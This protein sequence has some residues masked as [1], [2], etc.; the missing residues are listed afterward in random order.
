VKITYI[1]N[2]GPDWSTESHIAA[3][4]EDMG[5]EVV[6]A[7]ERT[8]GI[9]LA[10]ELHK[11]HGL[12][13][14][15]T[16]S[17][18]EAEAKRSDLLLWTRTWGIDD[19]AGLLQRLAAEGVPTVAYHLDL[20]AGLERSKTLRSEPWWK[21]KHV[22]TPDGGS[23]DFWK[24]HGVNHHYLRPG[25]FHRE[26]YL[27]EPDPK[28]KTDVAFVGSYGYH[29]E[30]PY[31]RQLVD[32]LRETYRDRFRLFGSGGDTVRGEALNRLYAS[33][34]VCVGDSLCKDFVHER[35][36]SDRVHETPGR[37]GV[38]VMPRI[39]GLDECYVD[40]EEMAFYEFGNFEALKSWI[41]ELLENT[42]LRE[43]MRLAGH[44]RT[45]REHT[46]EHRLAEMFTVLA[47]HE[48]A[49]AKRLAA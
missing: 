16:T 11:N 21:C 2:F 45:K 37:G 15:W 7:Q 25:V 3:T 33:T 1:G 17:A 5:H 47:Q 14:G 10:A 44:V 46:Y 32:W 41:D 6:R 20:Y 39:V 29:P 28:Y 30:W 34:K 27:G 49:I 19:G 22:F 38:L 43:K 24:T 8:T 13:V 4:L 18:I 12:G 35:Y 9:A 40:G 42:E 48:P 36:W 31:R 23:G 26:C